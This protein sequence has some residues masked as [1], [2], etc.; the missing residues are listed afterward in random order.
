MSIVDALDFVR[1]TRDDYRLLEGISPEG[2][3]RMRQAGEMLARL[4]RA[5]GQPIPE[6]IRLIELELRLDI[7]LAAN[8]TRGPARV[9]STQ[10]RAFVD[11][12]RGF[13]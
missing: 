8:E 11:E 7:E 6:L 2:R 12:V 13:H 3:A 5:V 9:A 10:L 1:T 4:R